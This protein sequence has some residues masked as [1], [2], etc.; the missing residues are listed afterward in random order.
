MAV[1][2]GLRRLFTRRRILLAVG[3]VVAIAVG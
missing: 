1:A 2:T 3:L